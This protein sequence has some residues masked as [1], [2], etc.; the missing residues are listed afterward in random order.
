MIKFCHYIEKWHGNFFQVY[1][2]PT[3]FHPVFNE[4]VFLVTV[5]HELSVGFA[6]LARTI[7]YPFFHAEKILYGFLIINM[8]KKSHIFVDQ[9]PE[10]VKKQ[11]SHIQE[12]PRDYSV[13]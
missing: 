12:I 6:C 1:P 3:D 13:I 2:F 8:F 9:K 5:L 4:K 10:R 11:E 7:K